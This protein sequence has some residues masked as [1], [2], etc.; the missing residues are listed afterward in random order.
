MGYLF[1]LQ[2]THRDLWLEIS[3]RKFPLKMDPV[4]VFSSTIFSSWKVLKEY[5]TCPDPDMILRV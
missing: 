1:G 3:S 2:E 4:E 5:G